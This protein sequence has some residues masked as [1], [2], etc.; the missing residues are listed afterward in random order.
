[1]KKSLIAALILLLFL[2]ACGKPPSSPAAPPP[3]PAPEQTEAPALE[4]AWGS[5]LIIDVRE[6]GLVVLL[7]DPWDIT[8]SRKPSGTA[9]MPMPGKVSFASEDL[10][11]QLLPGMT[12]QFSGGIDSIQ[13]SSPVQA[14]PIELMAVSYDGGLISL[15][16]EVLE[17]LEVRCPEL[18]QGTSRLCIDLHNAANL[19]Y[20]ADGAIA[21]CAGGWF[22]REVMTDTL[23]GLYD[24]GYLGPVPDLR[25]EDGVFM[26]IKTEDVAED[27][28]TLLCTKQRS[29][30]EKLSLTF[31]CQ[32]AG[33]LWTWREE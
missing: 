1:M 30:E 15:Y 23:G 33:G 29:R 25:W 18:D 8:I 5:A 21:W 12:V 27:S 20:G 2:T 14:A 9:V 28:F 24:K 17:E 26:E 11:T 32:R 22:D 7:D 10:G 4:N 13:L 6:G 3:S 19:P 31:K 16:R